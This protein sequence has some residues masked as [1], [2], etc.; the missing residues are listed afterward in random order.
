MHVCLFTNTD[1]LQAGLTLPDAPLML[2]TAY[3]G[4][5]GHASIVL[6]KQPAPIP[7]LDKLICSMTEHISNQ[8]LEKRKEKNELRFS[9]ITTRA[10]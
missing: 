3:A 9:A 6:S 8:L 4:S 1:E 7:L 2:G 10:S 5:T